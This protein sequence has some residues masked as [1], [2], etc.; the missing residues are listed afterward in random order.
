MKALQLNTFEGKSVLLQADIPQPLPAD[1]QVLVRVHALGV[2]PLELQW[3]P[4]SHMKSGERRE[5]AIPGHEFS[6]VIAALGRAVQG[7]SIGD[8]IYGMNDWFA[9][10]AAAEYCL[11]E[12]ASIAPKPRTLTHSKA[13]TVPISALTAWQALFDRARLL[14]GEK[15]LVLGGTGGVGLFAVQLAHAHRATVTATVSSQN[16]P[17]VLQLGASEAIDYRASWIDG[18]SQEF[19]VV[20][21]TVGG[22]TLEKSW[23]MLKDSGRMVT[24]ATESEGTGD[25]RTKDAFFIVEPKSDQLVEIAQR[26]DKGGLMCFVNASFPFEDGAS[27][28]AGHVKGSRGFGKVVISV[29][30]D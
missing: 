25:Q 16:V 22:E 14:T 7:L 27:A 23:A 10:G 19:D 17:F 20:F 9:D 11:T 13:A 18:R 4:T 2:T 1:N 29:L 28:F 3:Y 21:D 30:P 24:I 12:P 26:L 5:R 15:I 6:G 8:E